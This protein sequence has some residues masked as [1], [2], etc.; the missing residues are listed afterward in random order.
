M[1]TYIA[2]DRVMF[3]YNN[4]SKDTFDAVL[5]FLH[6]VW[7]LPFHNGNIQDSVEFEFHFNRELDR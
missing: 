2:K 4:P 1:K 3:V 6:F 5:R 7:S